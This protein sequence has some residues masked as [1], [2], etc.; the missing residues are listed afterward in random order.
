MIADHV[1]AARERRRRPFKAA[2]HRDDDVHIAWASQQ[3]FGQRPA[4]LDRLTVQLD[5]PLDVDEKTL[6]IPVIGCRRQVAEFLEAT[7]IV[8]NQI[9]HEIGQADE[10]HERLGIDRVGQ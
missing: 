1:A 8:G 9:Q 3:P 10:P 7:N 5:E 2:R 6:H 4:L